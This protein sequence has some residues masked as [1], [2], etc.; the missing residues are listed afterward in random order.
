M[1]NSV[2][3][4]IYSAHCWHFIICWHDKYIRETLNKKIINKNCHA[5]K[6]I[7]YWLP[8]H[9]QRKKPQNNN[10]KNKKKTK[11][12]QT[13]KQTNKQKQ[14]KYTRTHQFAIICFKRFHQNFQQMSLLH[15]DSFKLPN[16]IH[17]GESNSTN[18]CCQRCWSGDISSDYSD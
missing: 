5:P 15:F 9:P 13:N 18:C 12:K 4:E 17:L 10:R 1:P 7:Q 8:P 2:E 3:L 14:N 6:N 16:A 11:N